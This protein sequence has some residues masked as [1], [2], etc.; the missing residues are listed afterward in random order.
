MSDSYWLASYLKSGNTWL[1]M[2]LANLSAGGEAKDINALP[3]HSGIA[4]ARR[5]FDNLLL[6]ESGLLTAD[7]VDCLRPRL[8]AALASGAPAEVGDVP[9]RG[10]RFTKVHDAY[11]MT[12][13]GEPLLAGARGGKGAIVIVRDPRDIAPSLANHNGVTIDRAIDQLND[14][15]AVAFAALETQPVQLR[16]K[17]GDWSGHVASWLGQHDIPVHLV[18]YEDLLSDTPRIFQ[19]VL[20]FAGLAAGHAEVEAAIRS[21]DF[22]RLQAQEQAMG[23]AE[24]ARRGSVFFRRGQAGAWRDELTVAQ[25]R[26]IEQAHGAMMQRLGYELSQR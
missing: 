24:A 18:R 6:I 23:F 8:H 26:R 15:S 1:R 12:A 9:A 22:A 14:T 25:V 4:N 16:S 10:P 13:G 2:L 5:P 20:T 3:A 17:L 11:A 7:E 21:S 19:Q